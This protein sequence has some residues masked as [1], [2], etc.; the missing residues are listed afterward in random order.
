MQKL[1]KKVRSKQ[2]SPQRVLARVL[3]QELRHLQGC[4]IVQ[5]LALVQTG[6]AVRDISDGNEMDTFVG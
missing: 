5:S 1:V 4:G 2:G 6:G 3:A